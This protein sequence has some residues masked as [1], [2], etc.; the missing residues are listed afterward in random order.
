[1]KLADLHCDIELMHQARLAAD[2]MLRADPELTH[3]EHQLLAQKIR[4]LFETTG[5]GLN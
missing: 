1:M 2:N 5:D 3:P 4:Q